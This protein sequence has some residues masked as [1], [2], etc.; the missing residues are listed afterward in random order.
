MPVFT[1]YAVK[2]PGSTPE[3]A[4]FFSSLQRPDQTAFL[5]GKAPMA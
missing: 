5:G 2:G 4:L 3:S 1:S